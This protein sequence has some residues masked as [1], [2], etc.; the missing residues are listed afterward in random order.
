V[1]VKQGINAWMPPAGGRLREATRG[2]G[3][4]GMN[5]DENRVGGCLISERGVGISD[6]GPILEAFEEVLKNEPEFLTAE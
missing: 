6:S 5:T 4:N 2:A 1:S 3:A